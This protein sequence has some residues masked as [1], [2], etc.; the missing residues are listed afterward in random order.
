M[1]HSCEALPSC[2]HVV[3][4]GDASGLGR[5]WAWHSDP[6][7]QP[8][9]A[10]VGVAAPCDVVGDAID[11]AAL[12][13]VDRLRAVLAL[14]EASPGGFLRVFRV[15]CSVCGANHLERAE[16]AVRAMR[17]YVHAD[18]VEALREACVPESLLVQPSLLGVSRSRPSRARR[19][20]PASLPVWPGDPQRT[21]LAQVAFAVQYAAARVL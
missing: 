11:G 17:C 3:C 10:S 7:R 21:R 12:C 13:G 5:G 18:A 1:P 8:C 19:K 2:P 6:H 16:R 14:R 20:L 15:A 4:A 9:F